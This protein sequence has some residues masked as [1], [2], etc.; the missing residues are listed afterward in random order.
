MMLVTLTTDTYSREWFIDESMTTD[1][2]QE[3]QEA[4]ACLNFLSSYS[5]RKELV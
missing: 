5:T 3:W 4:L 2:P 1:F